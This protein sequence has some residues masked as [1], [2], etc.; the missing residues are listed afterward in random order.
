MTYVGSVFT[1][2][3]RVCG[4]DRSRTMSRTNRL[5]GRVERLRGTALAAGLR[6]RL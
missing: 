4:R 6:L 2:C 3:A 1:A 5:G